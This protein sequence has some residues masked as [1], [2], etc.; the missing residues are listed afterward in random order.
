[1]P[2]ITKTDIGRRMYQLHKEKGVEK[3]T[4]KIR[5][6]L[7]AEWKTVP[8]ADIRLL[9]QLLGVAWVSFDSKIWEKIPFGRMNREDVERILD[10]GRFLNLDTAP[11]TQVLEQ[12]ER[13]LLAGVA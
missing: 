12:L 6:S 1:M 3:A 7:G 13:V 4:E 10:T 5:E 11:K 9:E 8:D 2:D